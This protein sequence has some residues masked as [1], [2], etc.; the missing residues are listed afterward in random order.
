MN[1]LR[2]YIRKIIAESLIHPK[3]TKQ[4]Q[5]VKSSKLIVFAGFNSSGPDFGTCTVEIAE[6]GPS[7]GRIIAR[8][9]ATSQ[10]NAGNCNGAFIISAQGVFAERGIGP[11]IYD[12]A[13][14]LAELA[15]FDG[16]GPDPREVSSDAKAVWD[17]YLKKRPDITPKQRDFKEAPITDTEEDD[18]LGQDSAAAAFPAVRLGRPYTMEEVK[19]MLVD[20]PEMFLQYFQK[21][22]YTGSGWSKVQFTEEQIENWIRDNWIDPKS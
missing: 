14:E 5:K 3:I 1:L 2:H 21:R 17:Y 22:E 13:F 6:D 12:I 4:L 8:I 19:T 10:K 9:Q 11:L 15:G 18:C 7:G 20:N 16:L